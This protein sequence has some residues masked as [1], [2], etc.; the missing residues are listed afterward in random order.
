MNIAAVFFHLAAFTLLK[1]TALNTKPFPKDF[2]FGVGTSSFQIE[3]AWNEDG[4][5]ENIWDYIT[6]T[7]HWNYTGDVAC[8]SYH[9]YKEDVA[10]LKELGVNHYRFS[11]SWSRL[12]PTGFTNKV[13][14]AGVQYYKNLIKELKD[15]GIEPLVT[16]YH[17][18]MPQPLQDLGGFLNDNFVD[19]FGDY[20]E[21]CFELFGDDVSNWLTFNEPGIVCVFGYGVAWIPP[22]ILGQGFG[23]YMCGKNLVLAHARAWHIYDT[24]FRAKQ[25]GSV[26][27]VTVSDWYEPNSNKTEDIQ[28]AEVALQF[29]WGLYIKP[30]IDG[31]Y[32]SVVKEQMARR[33]KQ[34]GFKRSRL[35][36][37]TKEQQ[38][39]MSGTL[40]FIGLNHYTTYL[41]GA[42]ESD[43]DPSAMGYF[44]D[45]EVWRYQP[46]DWEQGGQD[47][48][49]VVPWGMRK[50]LKWMKDTFNNP[51]III[52][53]NGFSDN[54]QNLLDDD[55]R[56]NYIKNY[57]S[58]V[59]DAIEIDGVNVAAYT[60]WSLMDNYE[61][62]SYDV[63]Y[64]LYHVDF[65]SPNRT[66]TMKK[67]A[68][69]Y[70]KVVA[71]RSVVEE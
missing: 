58:N 54:K 41:V 61:W 7:R 46:D 69:Y 49:K 37:F 60:L 65:N 53:E 14:E 27:M 48:L 59:R 45:V 70:K 17:W 29:V 25:K 11:L 23:E 31:D 4:K 56:I 32:S 42:Q 16:I 1:V 36:E 19:W 33:S 39:Y 71:T 66:R 38:T 50:L 2:K 26:G 34:Q 68:E 5:G 15:N 57:L 8:D 63:K 40:D 35:T 10:M 30:L 28:A 21:L 64:G 43:P 6:H 51:K 18:D 22:N 13:N 62:G 20:A 9:K 12:L 55:R 44:Q 47:F 67:S 24:K 52:T 3:G